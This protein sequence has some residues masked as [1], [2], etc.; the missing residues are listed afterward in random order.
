MSDNDEDDSFCHF[1]IDGNIGWMG[2]LPE[3]EEAHVNDTGWTVLQ[4]LPTISTFDQITHEVWETAKTEIRIVRGNIKSLLGIQTLSE[5]SS[6]QLYD[7]VFGTNSWLWKV[8]DQ[9]LNHGGIYL[10]SH[11]LSHERF[12]KIIGSFFCASSLGLS[13]TAIWSEPLLDTS[14]FCTFEEYTLFWK[15]VTKADHGKRYDVSTEYLWMKM[16]DVINQLCRTIF[17]RDWEPYQQKCITIDDDKVHY[18][19]NMGHYSTAG[20]KPNQLVRDNR[21]G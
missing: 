4:D 21:R 8:V 9:T 20:L 14:E 6:N 12:L 11:P 18:N 3:E 13:A 1:G 16:V 17:L 15:N 19:G 10:E 7:L 5:F 2:F